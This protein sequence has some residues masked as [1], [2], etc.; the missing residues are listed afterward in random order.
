MSILII[1]IIIVLI[2]IGK[3]LIKRVEKLKYK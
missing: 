1:G 3:I 2:I